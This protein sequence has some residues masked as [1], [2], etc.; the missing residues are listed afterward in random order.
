M[1]HPSWVRGLKPETCASKHID[2]QVAPLVG[3]WI[4]TRLLR[5][6]VVPVIVAPLVGA[7][8]ETKSLQILRRYGL[9]HPS[10]VRG[11][12]RNRLC[13]KKPVYRSHPSWVRGLK[14]W[15]FQHRLCIAQS[16]PSWV[17]GLKPNV[18]TYTYL[19]I[20]VAPLVGAWI[21]TPYI[22]QRMQIRLVAP[23]VGAWIETRPSVSATISRPVAPLVGA[24][25]ETPRWTQ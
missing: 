12:K 15:C 11:L 14:L 24:W 22:L 3:A 9:S 4:E 25:I 6:Q 20:S 7:W 2:Q 8:I 21:E 19:D 5:Q 18:S 10:W 17:R 16:H 1:S 23:L 13:K